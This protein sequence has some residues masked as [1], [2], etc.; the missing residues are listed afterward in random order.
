MYSLRR[1][2]TENIHWNYSNTYTL[3]LMA[4]ALLQVTE[5]TVTEIVATFV[6]AGSLLSFSFKSNVVPRNI[7]QLLKS[8]SLR[9]WLT[10]RNFSTILP[11]GTVFVY[12]PYPINTHHNTISKEENKTLWCVNKFLHIEIL[13]VISKLKIKS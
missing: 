10:H 6:I 13:S 3:F 2:W 5:G 4:W 12:S 11:L 9:V 7:V 8:D 1:P